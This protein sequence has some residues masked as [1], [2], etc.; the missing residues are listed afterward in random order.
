[1]AVEG[2]LKPRLAARFQN[3]LEARA[4]VTARAFRLC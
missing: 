2:K 1:L 3:E 4:A